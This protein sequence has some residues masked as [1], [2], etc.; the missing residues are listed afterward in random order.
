[1]IARGKVTNPTTIAV[2]DD[3]EAGERQ[4]LAVTP[5][6][7]CG[8]ET[9]TI[10][11]EMGEEDD[12]GWHNQWRPKSKK[13]PGPFRKAPVEAKRERY[14]DDVCEQHDVTEILDGTTKTTVLKQFPWDRTQRLGSIAQP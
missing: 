1:M 11:S 12:L 6:C 4:R 13:V 8:A 9:V 7:R 2:R 3:E 5:E 14:G 10:Q